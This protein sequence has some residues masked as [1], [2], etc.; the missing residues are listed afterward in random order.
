ME[1]ICSVQSV[2]KKIKGKEIA[3]NVSFEVSKGEIVGLLGPNGAGKTTTMKMIVGLSEISVGDIKIMGYSIKDHLSKA[4]NNIGAV[5]EE[6][7][8]YPYLTGNENLR[9]YQR[10]HKTDDRKWLLEV[11]NLV[12]IEYALKQRV[13]T[14]SMG[15]KQRLGIAQALLKKPKLLVLDEPT[16][17][18]DPVGIR[19]IREYLKQLAGNLGMG[20][21]ISSHQL[22]EIEKIA[23]RVII[24]QDGRIFADQQIGDVTNDGFSR[25]IL[26]IDDAEH[27]SKIVAELFGVNSSVS[28]SITAERL[29]NQLYTVALTI[30]ENQIP[31]LLT[32]LCI[33]GISVFRVLSLSTTLEE[34]YLKLTNSKS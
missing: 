5:I 22:S 13:A 10:M 19:D 4:L 21:L 12:G 24:M 32:S 31:K 33:V 7:T 15:M 30:N 23:D 11:A 25:I 20:I 2:T 1:T 9:Q 14:Y 28:K 3:Q 29:P 34:Q 26:H 18:L 16:N 17:G 6:P 27:T 8:F